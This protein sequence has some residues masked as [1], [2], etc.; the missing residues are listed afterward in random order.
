MSI[1]SDSA[2]YLAS[3]LYIA[4]SRLIMIECEVS[5]KGMSKHT[6]ITLHVGG[7]EV[8]ESKHK[9]FV[10]AYSC[11]TIRQVSLFTHK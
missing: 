11:D 7:V 1:F 3:V 9:F 10:L 2:I 8:W 6:H 5:F 4:D